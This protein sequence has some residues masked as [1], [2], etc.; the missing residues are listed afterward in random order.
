M[1]GFFWPFKVNA[2]IAGFGVSPKMFDSATR[3]DVQIL[4]KKVKLMRFETALLFMALHYSSVTLYDNFYAILYALLV[5]N[6]IDC[7]KNEM[8]DVLDWLQLK[9][10]VDSWAQKGHFVGPN[11]LNIEIWNNARMRA[12]EIYMGTAESDDDFLKESNDYDAGLKAVR[13]AKTPIAQ[14]FAEKRANLMES[15]VS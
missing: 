4:G 12:L 5:N 1:I 14:L 7:R 10:I 15:S 13:Y 6:K 3:S 9:S 2:A 8:Q 11:T